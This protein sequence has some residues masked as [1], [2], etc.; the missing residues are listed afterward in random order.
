MA[1]SF[2]NSA[3]IVAA[4]VALATCDARTPPTTS[5]SAPFDA[6]TL[7]T[8]LSTPW[9][10]AWGPDSMIWV[11]E[12][13]G[14]ISRV[15]PSTGSRSIA[16]KLDVREAGESGLMGIAFD[17]DFTRSPFVYAMHSY[18]VDGSIGNRLVRMRWDGH[19]LGAPSVLLDGIVGAGI[20]NG[21][22][23]AV[24]PDS[25]LYVS[26]GDAGRSEHAQNRESLNGK[27]L[28]LSLDGHAAPGNP[29]GNRVWSYGHRNPQ[30][31]VFHPTT[32]VLYETEHGP[33][34]NDEI[35]IVTRG[36]NYGWPEVHG[37]CDDEGERAFCTS[38][39]VV[40]ALWTWTPTIAPTGADFYMSDR[41]AGWK[42][43]LLFTAL[44][45]ALYRATL[46]ADGQSV[47]AVEKML[48]GEFGRLRDVLVGPTGEIYLATSNRDGRGSPRT[49]DDRILKLT[50]K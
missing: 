24:G 18:T 38:H 46:S 26:T 12:R 23:I 49:G 19:T 41:I 7:V 36:G 14:T 40:E 8:G 47:R 20:H 6:V 3:T 4:G 25:L 11:S 45:G 30:G 13:G 37:K 17:P 31:L 2:G 22:R 1:M 39:S 50:P 33:S 34:D 10:L 9:D 42:G 27:I 28:R 48:S 32:G 15:D 35:N 5:V 43:S 21:S 44:S 29:F 16:G